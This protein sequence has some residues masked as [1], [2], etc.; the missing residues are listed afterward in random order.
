MAPCSPIAGASTIPRAIQGRPIV[1]L[2]ADRNVGIVSEDGVL[3][4]QLARDPA[5]D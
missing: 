5:G 2:V 3:L 4:R 1:L